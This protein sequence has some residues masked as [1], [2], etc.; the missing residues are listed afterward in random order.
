MGGPFIERSGPGFALFRLA[1][2]ARMMIFSA[3]LVSVFFPWPVVGN[4]GLGILLT[5][6]KM[7]VVLTLVGVIDVVNPRLRIDQSMSYYA[8]VIVFVSIGALAIAIIG[9]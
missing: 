8:R 5:L 7:A 4:L 9:H 6:V 2:H 3:L 1:M